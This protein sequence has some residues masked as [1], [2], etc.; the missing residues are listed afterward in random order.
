ML[1]T[2][3]EFTRRHMFSAL[4]ALPLVSSKALAKSKA[5]IIII[6]GGF[7]GAT[8]ALTLKSLA[9]QINV[10]LIEPKPTYWAC[11]FSNLVLS[12]DRPLSAQS[13][14]YQGLRHRGVTVIQDYA[15]DIDP[16]RQAVITANGTDLSYDKLILSP[17]ISLRW[18]DIE[19]Y[20]E[21][22]AELMPHAWQAGPQTQLLKQ[23]IDAMPDGGVIA[24]SVPKAP[25]RCPPGP[26][27]RASLLAHY[28]KT[29]KP[30]SK[31]IIL[32]AKDSF[33][34]QAL[35]QQ[36][37]AEDYA[38]IIDWRS[39][40]NDGTVIR[41]DPK[42]HQIFTDFDDI[43]VDVANIIPPQRAGDIAARAGVT[44]QTGWCPVNG[45]TFESTLQKNIHI[46]GDAC[47][48]SPMPKSAFS[49]NL[50]AKICTMQI[51]R[52]L[53]GLAPISTTLTNTCY[54]Y[55]SPETA[56]SITG[57]YTAEAKQISQIAAAGG[58]S[59]LK[60]TNN[61]RQSEAK[62]AKAWFA[63]ATKEAFG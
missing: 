27:E 47:I 3:T 14:S 24:M 22:A 10:T 26:Y 13:Y 48:A 15:A 5:R 32:D 41:V 51:I 42:T 63:A 43:K 28:L 9:P 58:V 37:W 17:G 45:L 21:E 6:G 55:T 49:A 23:K 44:D 16:N 35:F 20:N 59:P 40:S 18:N 56:V 19:G 8:A 62:Q 36:A 2:M 46:I 12:G 34:K 53:A 11:P 25:Y 54:S 57:V 60:A 31:L 61:I 39:Y 38:N 4:A 33:S 1:I 50:Q 29:Q 7:G 52:S 30:K